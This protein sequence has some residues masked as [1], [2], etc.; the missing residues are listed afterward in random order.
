[1]VTDTLCKYKEDMD[2]FIDDKCLFEKYLTKREIS[3]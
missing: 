1:M 2:E 3:R